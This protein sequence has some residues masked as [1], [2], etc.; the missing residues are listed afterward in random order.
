MMDRF[1][2]IMLC[3]GFIVLAITSTS[4]AADPITFYFTNHAGLAFSQFQ[5]TN[6]LN[7]TNGMVYGGSNQYTITFSPFGNY[8]YTNDMGSSNFTVNHLISNLRAATITGSNFVFATNQSGVT[9]IIETTAGGSFTINNNLVLSNTVYVLNAASLALNGSISGNGNIT[10]DASLNPSVRSCTITNA[11]TFIGNW[12]NRSNSLLTFNIPPAVGNQANGVTVEYGGQVEYAAAQAL[13]ATSTNTV[14]QYGM[15]GG[16]SVAINSMTSGVNLVVT[17]PIGITHVTSGSTS[18]PVGLQTNQCILVTDALMSG[19]TNFTIGNAVATN[20]LGLGCGIVAGGTFGAANGVTIVSGD[21]TFLLGVGK[22]CVIAN[23]LTG[24]NSANT[25]T[26]RGPGILSLTSPLNDCQSKW[27]NIDGANMTW[28]NASGVITNIFADGSNSWG[29]L[30]RVTSGTN[31]IGWGNGSSNYNAALNLTAGEIDFIGN[32]SA[33]A[34]PFWFGAGLV[35]PSAAG[36]FV[37][38]NKATVWVAGIGNISGTYVINDGVYSNSASG[39]EGFITGASIIIS[40]GAVWYDNASQWAIGRSTGSKNVTAWIGGTNSLGQKSTLNRLGLGGTSVAGNS[41]P[42]YSNVMTIAAGGQV[43]NMTVFAVGQTTSS[44]GNRLDI[45][46]GA[47]YCSSTFDIASS[48]AGLI[49][50]Q[51]NVMVGGQLIA[52]GNMTVGSGA[53]ATNN[54]MIIDGTDIAGTRSF[55]SCAAF[56]MASGNS[57]T[58]NTLTVQ[59]Y[60]VFNPTS[61]AISA[62]TVTNWGNYVNVINGGFLGFNSATPAITTT[63]LLNGIVLSNATLSFKDTIGIIDLTNNWSAENLGV[64]IYGGTN[65]LRLDNSSATNSLASNYVFANNLGSTNFSKLE[66][67]SGT[68]ILRGGGVTIDAGHGGSILITNALASITGGLILSNTVSVIVGG[69]SALTNTVITGAGSFLKTGSGALTI[70]DMNTYTGSTIISNGVL[71]VVAPQDMPYTPLYIYTGATNNLNF[72]GTGIVQNLYL[73]NILQPMGL[74]NATVAPT[75]FMGSG[76]V[77]STGTTN[78]VWTGYGTS[79]NWNEPT[80]WGNSVS[81]SAGSILCFYDSPKTVSTNNFAANTKFGGITFLPNAVAFNLQG[82]AISFVG[83]IVNNSTNIQVFNMVCAGFTNNVNVNCASNNIVFSNNVTLGPWTKLGTNRMTVNSG[84]PAYIDVEAGILEFAGSS[85]STVTNAVTN[86][87]VVL[88]NRTATAT[89]SGLMSGTG[90]WS[91]ASGGGT[92]NSYTFSGVS[93]TLSGIIYVTNSNTRLS[94]GSTLGPD[95]LGNCPEIHASNGGQIRIDNAGTYTQTLYLA[96]SGYS[97]EVPSL[98][99]LRIGQVLSPD[100]YYAGNIILTG[101]S[102]IGNHG[103][104]SNVVFS[105]NISGAYTLTIRHDSQ[106]ARY[107]L[108]PS[109]VNT[110]TGLVVE[111]GTVTM[112]NTNSINPSCIITIGG[113]SGYSARQTNSAYLDLNGFSLSVTNNL[114]A[115]V[116]DGLEGYIGS[117][118]TTSSIV[119]IGSDNGSLVLG[120]S[121]DNVTV[122]KLGSGTLTMQTTV[123]GAGVLVP[124]PYSLNVQAGLISFA[125]NCI[126][127]AK[128]VLVYSGASCVINATNSII[129]DNSYIDIMRRGNLTLGTN[130]NEVVNFLYFGNYNA[131]VPGNWNIQRVRID[132]SDLINTNYISGIG[133]LMV[134][135]GASKNDVLTKSKIFGGM[136]R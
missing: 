7:T 8:T 54:T 1:K 34:P 67:T 127:N 92:T 40:N 107:T 53:G 16:S 33:S 82:N 74:Y 49:A 25:I 103:G 134:L 113:N 89:F 68:N 70:S 29:T 106:L 32:G 87:S 26:L 97:G 114:Y 88:I 124:V 6:N 35:A 99:A 101:D 71:S 129:I 10:N 126:G 135:K 52:G 69:S 130:V 44:A 84:Y 61:I 11:N 4:F 47:L 58:G 104:I 24:G 22:T 42:T 60:G 62:T 120:N 23:H 28:G 18:I 90:I 95:R 105:G 132:G 46:G 55:V 121:F 119:N 111:S 59:N 131:Q 38:S 56:S 86:N 76:N 117:L 109:V 20:W 27:A 36:V 110:F 93:N 136:K 83:G 123:N 115:P 118:S 17:Y 19:L 72:V 5:G 102:V 51:V 65:T 48:A 98:G 15:V 30:T 108:Q 3:V 91:F 13:Y 50:N 73:D 37:V 125:T 43:T 66:F 12:Y 2:N 96:G 116:S 80:N 128:N 75:Y 112:G 63:G 94:E 81:P 39:T 133:T 85:G 64:I 9:P 31:V 57:A 79:A 41:G 14:Q 77:Y 100:S 78:P 45:T 122:N 21:S